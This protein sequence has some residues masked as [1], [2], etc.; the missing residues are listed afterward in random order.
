MTTI[1]VWKGARRIKRKAQDQG[2]SNM[3]DTK[4]PSFHRENRK[5]RNIAPRP[6]SNRPAI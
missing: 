5:E 6:R 1:L 2:T 4:I 3:H